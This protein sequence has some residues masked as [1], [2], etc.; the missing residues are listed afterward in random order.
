VNWNRRLSEDFTINAGIHSQYLQVSDKFTLEPRLSMQ[1]NFLPA[2]SFT[3]GWGIYRQSLPLVI[4][5]GKSQNESL[6]FMQSIHYVAGYSY[7]LSYDAIIKIEG[8]YK[9]ISKAPVEASEKS[10]WSFL[11]SGTSFG[12]VEG[13]GILAKST[14]LGKAYGAELSFLKHFS[15]GYYVTATGSFVRQEYKGSDDIWRYGAFDNKYVLNIL[16]G[17]EW[18]L[19]PELTLEFAGRFTTAGGAPYTPIDIEKSK[20]RNSTRYN[21]ALAYTLRNTP[22]SRF[23]LRL[24]IRNN[25]DNFSIISYISAENL[26]STENIYMRYYSQSSDTIK[27]VYQLGFFFVGGVRIEF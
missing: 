19:N 23:D 17:Y 27:E 21:E 8:Y 6:D 24:D 15:D 5:Y 13:E 25:L 14:G 2:H 12:I 10:S 1:W 7:Q 9:D 16:S 20:E 4:Y 22:Y 18:V 3:L 11:N 26:F